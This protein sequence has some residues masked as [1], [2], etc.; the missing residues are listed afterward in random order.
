M[1]RPSRIEIE[2]S[3]RSRTDHD[4]NPTRPKRLW[5]NNTRTQ[6]QARVLGGDLSGIKKKKSSKNPIW[7]ITSIALILLSG[8]VFIIPEFIDN[9]NAPKISQNKEKAPTNNI[10]QDSRIKEQTEEEKLITNS[11]AF[12][13]PQDRERAEEYREQDAKEQRLKTLKKQAQTAIA[14]GNYTKPEDASA[15]NYFQQI[16]DIDANNSFAL[17]GINY[18]TNRLHTI[19]MKEVE[20]S[21]LRAARRHLAAL[22]SINSDSEKY[23]ELSE[24]ISTLEIKLEKEAVQKDIQKILARAEKAIARKRYTTPASD[25]ALRYYQQVLQK[26]E[27]NLPAQQGINQVVEFYRERTFEAIKDNDWQK[28]ERSI[29]A[30]NLIPSQENLIVELNNELTLAKSPPQQSLVTSESSITKVQTDET[31][32]TDAVETANQ[33][34]TEPALITNI[35]PGGQPSSTQPQQELAPTQDLSVQTN[36]VPEK[37]NFQ[38]S[39]PVSDSLNANSSRNQTE[40]AQ[41]NTGLQAYYNSE[42]VTAFTNLAPLAE[43]NNTRA[44]IRIGYMYQFGRG[45]TQNKEVGS[46]YLR[47]ALPELRKLA[48]QNNAWA[49]ADLGSLYEDGIVVTQSFTEALVWYRKAAAQN[50][51]GAQTNLGNMY[52]FGK[53][54]EQSQSEAI[55]WY[56][57]AAAGGDA[58]AKQNL[59]QLGALDF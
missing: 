23:I 43:K 13:I 55:R 53:G 49:Q 15:Y 41:L 59:I 27:N 36:A 1:N 38:T 30:L 8:L 37:E 12:T 5:K 28:A 21:N 47:N 2:K 35:E 17:K 9:E 34:Q 20:S 45:V 54:V 29:D 58:I 24:A 33:Q 56:R 22:F 4:F 19:G 48:N 11:D 57:L 16:L 46:T 40:Q 26:D 39:A 18:L 25:N 10:Y 32:T 42:Y 3:V 14:S 52:F 50:Y 6:R 31:Q 44:Q 51:T 7:W